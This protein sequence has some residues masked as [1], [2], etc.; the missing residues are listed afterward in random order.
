MDMEPTGISPAAEWN[1][2]GWTSDCHASV[3][4]YLAMT[5]P[6]FSASTKGVPLSQHAFCGLG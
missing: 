3:R 5:C 1:A 2:P 6:E 4:T